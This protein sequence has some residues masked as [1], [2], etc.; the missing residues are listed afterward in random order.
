MVAIKTHVA[1][2]PHLSCCVS[3]FPFL[4]GQEHNISGGCRCSVQS[5]R[6][7]AVRWV[8]TVTA[9]F[10]SWILCTWLELNVLL[11]SQSFRNNRECC[12]A[13]LSKL[14][15]LS[16]NKAWFFLCVC[17]CEQCPIVPLQTLQNAWLSNAES[18]L[19]F[20]F[21]P[22]VLALHRRDFNLNF[23]WIWIERVISWCSLMRWEK[24]E[25]REGRAVPRSFLF[26]TVF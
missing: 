3:I 19:L 26:F 18:K 7:S 15:I 1:D 20:N 16:G 14:T 13:F 10:L 23:D 9:S 21:A 4:K 2:F 12:V 25:L 8:W 11:I 24:G 22:R 5:S 6:S 17:M